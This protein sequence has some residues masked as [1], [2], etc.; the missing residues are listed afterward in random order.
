M[1]PQSGIKNQSLRF[2][3]LF[4]HELSKRSNAILE[5]CAGRQCIW[6]LVE[7]IKPEELVILKRQHFF[8]CNLHLRMPYVINM[9]CKLQHIFGKGKL[10]RDQGTECIDPDWE[11]TATNMGQCRQLPVGSS[12]SALP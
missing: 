12:C 1:R 6:I 7:D 11:T 10:Y 8:Y 9:I 5:K 4:S 3:G 2:T